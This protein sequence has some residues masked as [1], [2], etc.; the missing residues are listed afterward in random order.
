MA[1]FPD[2]PQLISCTFFGN[3]APRCGGGIYLA[4]NSAPTVAYTIIAFSVSGESVFGPLDADITLACCDV[5]G[6]AGGDWV[7]CIADQYGIN[8]NICEDPLFCDPEEVDFSLAADSPCAP[9]TPPNEEC[10][11]IGAWP[12][13]C[14]PMGLPSNRQP[15]A[16]NWLLSVAPNPFTARTR[17]L[18][19]V[20]TCAGDAAQLS[21]H[22]PGGRRVRIVSWEPAPSG[23][24][25]IAW[26]GRDEAGNPLGSGVYFVRLRAGGQELTRRLLVV[27]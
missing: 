3:E 11:L 17:I 27:R 7:E 23:T 24:H 8:G 13:G 26:D 14:G 1:C 10:D 16:S 22:D 5:F 15:E 2:S 6:N 4:P 12:V 25:T 19:S 9:F 21:I 18:L 20:P